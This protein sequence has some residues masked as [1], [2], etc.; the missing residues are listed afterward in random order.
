MSKIGGFGF[1]LMLSLLPGFAHAG[2]DMGNA[3]DNVAAEFRLSARVIVQRLELVESSVGSLFPTQIELTKLKAVISSGVTEVN[4]K[5]HIVKNGEEVDAWNYW[6]ARLAIDVNR[7]RWED[8]RKPLHTKER[9][10]LVLHEF[11]WV[12]GVDDTGFRYSERLI[13]LVDV[14]DYSPN[15]WWNPINPVNSIA[16]SLQQFDDRCKFPAVSLNLKKETEQI[17]VQ[18]QGDCTGIFRKVEIVKTSNITPPSSGVRGVFHHYYLRVYDSESK[19][20]GSMEF[21]PEWGKCLMPD[22]G[23]C[24]Q[25][26][27]MT[28][29]GVE[30]IFWYL[31][32]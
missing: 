18:P 21:E 15:I 3:G 27:Q 14:N 5:D 4:S 16:L 19:L 20:L 30:F 17:D 26:G 25:S 13:E 31:R 12:S 24:Q 32:E 2:W 8:L 7:S 6:P 1:L 9:L 29:G 28:I 11:L 10:R 23:A 22:E